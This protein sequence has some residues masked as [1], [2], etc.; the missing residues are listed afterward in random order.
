MTT[1]IETAA[2]NEMVE[3]EDVSAQRAPTKR[4]KIPKRDLDRLESFK[5]KLRK[6]KQDRRCIDAEANKLAAEVRRVDARRKRVSLRINELVAKERARTSIPIAVTKAKPMSYMN[7]LVHDELERIVAS[8]QPI[9]PD[10]TEC[11]YMENQHTGIIEVLYRVAENMEL[12]SFDSLDWKDYEMVCSPIP[13]F[14]GNDQVKILDYLLTDPVMMKSL[15]RPPKELD[16]IH[17][18]IN[19]IWSAYGSQ[20]GMNMVCLVVDTTGDMQSHLNK[21]KC[22]YV[23]KSEVNDGLGLM[24]IGHDMPSYYETQ[25]PS[26]QKCG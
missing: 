25:L 5:T 13:V 7:V 19:S 23:M 11:E 6:L 10:D 22:K 12:P 20:P 24:L 2:V 21:F 16:I 9:D 3:R 26:C 17:M 4:M 8:L 15:P 14:R 1:P 18:C